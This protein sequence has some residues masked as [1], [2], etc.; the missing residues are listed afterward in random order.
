MIAN[1][2]AFTAMFAYCVMASVA[3]YV[4]KDRNAFCH[5]GHVPCKPN[6]DAR[7][8]RFGAAWFWPVW[9][10]VFIGRTFASFIGR[11]ER[12]MAELDRR[13]SERERALGIGVES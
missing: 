4:M 6:C 3:Y 8:C 7:L 11:K 12:R 10:P 5:C 1:L 2:I 9:A 13:I